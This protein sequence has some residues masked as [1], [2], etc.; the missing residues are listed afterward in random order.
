MHQ[1]TVALLSQ[2]NQLQQPFSQLT[3]VWSLRSCDM[4]AIH[5][6]LAAACSHKWL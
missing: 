5:C 1:R 2:L 4:V 6:G 3:S